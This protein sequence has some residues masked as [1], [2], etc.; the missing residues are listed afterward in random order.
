MNEQLNAT[1]TEI[2]KGTQN[3]VIQ[4]AAFLQAQVPELVKEVLAWGFYSNLFILIGCLIVIFTSIFIAY[5][6]RNFIIDATAGAVFIIPLFICTFLML[7][8][9]DS[10][11]TLIKVQVAPRLYLIDYVKTIIK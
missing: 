10:A 9:F 11:S 3:A 5:K 6:F 4:G 7:F 8:V 2:L 1:L